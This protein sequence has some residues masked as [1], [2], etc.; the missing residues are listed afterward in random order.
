MDHARLQE[1]MRVLALRA[2]AAIMAVQARADMGID[3]KADASPVTDADRAADALISAGLATEFAGLQVVT[4]EN[5]ATHV[6]AQGAFLIVD[7]LD[8]TRE[9]VRR[10]GDFT[11]NIAYVEDGV[12][13]RGVIYAPA[14]KRLFYTTADGAAVEE[15]GACDPDSP[16]APDSLRV[17]RVSPDLAQGLRIVASR[18]HRD[19]ETE[20]YMARF[21]VSEVRSAGSSLK[22]ALLAAGEAD[23]YPRFGPTM[24]WDTAAGDAILRAA[25]G[26]VLRADDLS[27]LRYGKPDWRNP[28][29]IAHTPAVDPDPKD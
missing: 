15:T 19:A 18:S 7:P 28:G 13:L 21:D 27:V 9:F 11:V 16:P 5:T 3:A 26:H 17:L 23:L 2:G 10:N 20:A 12:P 8:G 6:A 24:E 22:F 29:F 1:V 25:G 14:R 4:E